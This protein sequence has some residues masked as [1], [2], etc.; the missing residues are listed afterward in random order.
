MA[1]SKKNKFDR[2]N[3][4]FDDFDDQ[5]FKRRKT[6]KN[7]GIYEDDFLEELDNYYNGLDDKDFSASDYSSTEEN[8][9]D[10][11]YDNDDEK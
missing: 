3:G 4:Y 2:S 11:Y 9:K 8:D 5:N 1:K 10:L 7:K 6:L